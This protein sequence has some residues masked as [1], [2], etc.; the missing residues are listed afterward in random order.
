MLP[1]GRHACRCGH[2]AHGNDGPVAPWPHSRVGVAIGRVPRGGWNR[3]RR[4]CPCASLL[5]RRCPRRDPSL[6]ARYSSRGSATIPSDS[7]CPPLAFTV[8]YTSCMALT[9]AGHPYPVTD[10][11]DCRHLR[12][13]GDDASVWPARTHGE[14]M[15][16]LRDEQGRQHDPYLVGKFEKLIESSRFKTQ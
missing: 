11:G 7:R 16:V 12:R 3:S 10:R 14:I 1:T 2:T 13:H 5:V 9:R 4:S 6:L 8:A 15:A